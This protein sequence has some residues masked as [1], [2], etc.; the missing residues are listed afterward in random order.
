LTR[1]G[2]VIPF[3]LEVIKSTEA[4][5]PEDLEYKWNETGV[6]ICTDEQG[7]T[8]C[9]KL[10]SSFF[11]SLKIK[12]VSEATI[13]KMYDY[14]LDNIIK[15][16]SASQ[17]DF[18]KIEGFGKRLAERTYDNIHNGLQNITLSL[19]LGASGIFGMSIGVRKVESLLES[20]PNLLDVY[21]DMSEEDL[22][23]LINSVDGFSDKTT[24]K[25]IENLP[26]ADKFYNNM[27]PYIS[28]KVSETSYTD[29]KD[30]KIVFSGFRDTELEEIIKERGGK[31]STSVSKNTSLLI[32]NDTDTSS[33]K[34]KKAKDLGVQIMR[35]DEFISKYNF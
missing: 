27:K 22:R 14:G 35:K 7:G 1:S 17:E 33:S 9:V 21:K 34:Y 29:F 6:D 5:L 12:H 3:I 25:I 26:W 23:K 13:S 30:M 18:E 20:L 24:N 28:L 19:L 32:V 2:D 4:A 31:V 15:I 8:S 10:L 16:V 11:S